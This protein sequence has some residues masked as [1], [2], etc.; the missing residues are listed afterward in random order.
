[1]IG[2]MYRP[3]PNRINLFF[4]TEVHLLY[5]LVH[6]IVFN[7]SPFD[8]TTLAIAKNNA[9]SHLMCITRAAPAWFEWS[10]HFKLFDWVEFCQRLFFEPTARKIILQNST[11]S[12][13]LKCKPNS[14]I[15]QVLL[16]WDTLSGCG[17]CFSRWKKMASQ[18]NDTF[19]IL[20]TSCTP[21]FMGCVIVTTSTRT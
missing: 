15:K 18:K 8:S 21:C 17:H 19:D 4:L 10:E 5:L 9:R 20:L 11:K 12:K 3:T 16:W 1:M 7:V 14:K 2:S 13:S 6:V